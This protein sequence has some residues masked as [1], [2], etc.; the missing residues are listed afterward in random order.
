MLCVQCTCVQQA[1]GL[2]STFTS[3]VNSQRSDRAPCRSAVSDHSG[4]QPVVGLNSTIIRMEIVTEELKKLGSLIRI[5][6]T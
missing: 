4:V 5:K 2:Y 1:L 6:R 3:K